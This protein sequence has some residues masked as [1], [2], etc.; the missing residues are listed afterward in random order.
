MTRRQRAGKGGKDYHGCGN[1]G[2]PVCSPGRDLL[3]PTRQE[4]RADADLDEGFEDLGSVGSL[5]IGPYDYDGNASPGHR[6]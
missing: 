3:G 6:Q 2:C 4:L 5:K 1:P